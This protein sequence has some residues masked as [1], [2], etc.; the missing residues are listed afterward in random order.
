[1][2]LEAC[3]YFTKWTQRTV[4]A[5]FIAGE[6]LAE[7]YVHT[8]GNTAWLNPKKTPEGQADTR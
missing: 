4:V 6:S 7:Q 5:V 3:L 1:M 2:T 8:C